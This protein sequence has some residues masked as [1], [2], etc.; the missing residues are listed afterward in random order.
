MGVGVLPEQRQK[1]EGLYWGSR[2][3]R[4]SM[5]EEDEFDLMRWEGS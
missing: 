3:K 2:Q 1:C 4:K 5:S